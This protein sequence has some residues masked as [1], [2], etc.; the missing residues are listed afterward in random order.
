MADPRRARV[1]H[2]ATRVAQT[3]YAG[4]TGACRS[5]SPMVNAATGPDDQEQEG[6]SQ[7]AT[8]QPDGCTATPSLVL[9]SRS[10]SR[11]RPEML[12]GRRALAMDTELLRY[13]LAPNHHNE[14]LQ[15]IE[16]LVVAAGD[17]AALYLSF[18][19]Q[20]SLANDDEQDVPPP[21]PRREVCPEPR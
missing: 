11:A 6:S 21:P 9:A 5:P 2:C 13:R 15:C 1:E 8:E 12:H 3:V 18:R 10:A 14:W 16:E 7:P 20:S 4:P 19:P 17:S